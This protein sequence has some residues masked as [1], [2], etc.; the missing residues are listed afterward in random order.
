MGGVGDAFVSPSDRAAK[1]TPL[2]SRMAVV[3]RSD[4]RPA[5][6]DGILKGRPVFLLLGGPSLGSLDLGRLSARGI[7][8]MA[9]NNAWLMHRT[10]MFV[11]S[12]PP[13]RFAD[14]GWHDP[15]ITKFLPFSHV[16]S[17]LRSFTDGAFRETRFESN[18]M[19]NVWYFHRNDYFDPETF[20]DESSCS[21]G[22]M[23]NRRDAIGI[24]SS[25]STMLIAIKLLS[26]LGAGEIFLLGADFK[27]DLDMSARAYAWGEK[28]HES[29]RRSNNAGYASLAKRL[30][31]L[32]PHAPLKIWNCNPASGLRCFPHASFDE[33]IERASS[34]CS[35]D[36]P[37]AGWY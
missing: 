21:W 28:K 13:G 10:Q 3:F 30:T 24:S 35:R 12:D 5:P 2:P 33:A 25:R 37:L 19:P 26:W 9:V 6:L 34:V 17:K 4:G 32:V 16:R 7:C 20:F 1:R 14:T 11:C 36:V 27:M 18:Q 23:K 29:G 22:T 15:S 31:S 8:S